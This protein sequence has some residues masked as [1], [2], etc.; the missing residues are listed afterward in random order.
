MYV[1]MHVNV[2]LCKYIEMQT[3]EIAD[4]GMCNHSNA[5]YAPNSNI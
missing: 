2:Y 3:L 5:Q 4:N 1:R